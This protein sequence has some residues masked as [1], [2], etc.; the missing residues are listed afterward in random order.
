MLGIVLPVT[1]FVL[2]FQALVVPLFPMDSPHLQLFERLGAEWRAV[3]WLFVIILLSGLLHNLKTVLIRFYEG[4]PWQETRFGKWRV[5]CYQAELDTA[6]STRLRMRML[7]SQIRDVKVGGEC[8]S[9][10]AEKQR[11]AG[12][13]INNAFPQ[14][15]S[16]LPTRL[17]NVIRSFEVYPRRQYGISAITLWPRLIAK[18]DK[19]YAVAMDDT[20]TSF[21]FILICS[22]L[23]GILALSIFCVGLYYALPLTILPLGT[24]WLLETVLFAGLSYLFYVG[25]INRAGAWGTMVKGAFDLY[26]WALLEQLGFKQVP[27]TMAEERVLWETISLQMIYGDPPSGRLIE[28][29]SSPVYARCE[30]SRV[31]LV[32][33]RTVEPAAASRSIIIRL[34]VKNIDA[35]KR[36]AK[37]VILSDTVP[38]GFDYLTD[39]AKQATTSVA[40]TGVNPYHF[41]VGDIAYDHMVTLTYEMIS[42]KKGNA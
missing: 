41:E 10:I 28:Y 2:L 34:S 1:V 36:T 24:V 18:I 37:R 30:P 38:E 11:R 14:R 4:Y 31:E 39:S 33:T 13:Q 21:D 19:D 40:V 6:N 9:I 8:L 3:S 42:Q 29:T 23:S 20:K 7:A 22:A 12:Q 16:V 15:G 35:Q 17:G 5:R 25:A 32:L 26:R 27:T